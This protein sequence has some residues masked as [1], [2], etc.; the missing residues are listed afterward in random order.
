MSKAISVG[1]TS[2]ANFTPAFSNSSMIG[3]EPGP[4]RGEPVVDHFRRRR[5][6]R[7]QQVPDRTAGEPVDDADAEAGGRTGRWRSAPRRRARARRRDPRPPRRGAAGSPRDGRRCC[8]TP[9][10]RRG[11]RKSRTAPDR[12]CRAAPAW[13]RQ[14]SASALSTSKWSPQQASSSP[15]YPKETAISHMVPM[16]RSA[17]WPV[18]SVTGRA[19]MFSASWFL[20]KGPGCGSSR[21]PSP[22]ATPPRAPPAP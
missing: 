12:A 18:N 20:T 17:H 15:S 22:T 14:Y 21:V 4:E 3:L 7:V 2:R 13:P 1:W 11:G 6:K 9:P 5:G 8:R 19:M 16:S 10:G